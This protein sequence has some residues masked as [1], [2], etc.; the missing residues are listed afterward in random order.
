MLLL[1]KKW[2]KRKKK[3]KKVIDKGGKVCYDSEAL[4]GSERGGSWKAS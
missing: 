2:Q 1:K 3:W 4:A